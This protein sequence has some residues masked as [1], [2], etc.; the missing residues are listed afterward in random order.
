MRSPEST[1]HPGRTNPVSLTA[2]H[3]SRNMTS[4]TTQREAMPRSVER[5]SA[6]AHLSDVAQEMEHGLRPPTVT[7]LSVYARAIRDAGVDLDTGR[8]RR[9]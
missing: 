5:T 6:E 2:K 4:K 7:A 9:K 1:S 3:A 8:G